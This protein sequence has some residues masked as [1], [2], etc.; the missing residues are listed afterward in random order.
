MSSIILHTFDKKDL[1]E[2]ESILSV[3][4]A[5]NIFELFDELKY[6][7]IYESKGEELNILKSEF[8]DILNEYGLIPEGLSKDYIIS[9]LNPSWLNNN[10]KTL[11]VK[12]KTPFL[13]TILLRLENKFTNLKNIFY[14]YLIKMVTRNKIDPSQGAFVVAS[15]STVTSGGDGS[16]LPLILLPRPR[17]I[18][19][20]SSTSSAYTVVSQFLT[21]RGF[22]A[23]GAQTGT[24][25]GFTGIGLTFAFPGYNVYGFAGYTILTTV[26][27]DEIEFFPQI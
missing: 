24:L 6:K 1:K 19:F 2:K 16:I 27:A 23:Y 22:L 9:L 18:A 4:D 21:G 10:P 12:N 14:N 7:M 20:W 5:N 25:Y 3:E 11:L 8:I 26:T 15:F 17:A 13:T